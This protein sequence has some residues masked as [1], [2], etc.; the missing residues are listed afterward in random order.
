MTLAQAVSL[1]NSFLFQKCSDFLEMMANAEREAQASEQGENPV[2]AES[3][4][5]E[6]SENGD[7]PWVDKRKGKG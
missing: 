6:N 3:K 1:N 2:I 5:V 4:R 7:A